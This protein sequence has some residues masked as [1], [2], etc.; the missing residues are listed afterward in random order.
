MFSFNRLAS[1][2]YAKEELEGRSH[3]WQSRGYSKK[4]YIF[5]FT[6]D[7]A[8]YDSVV[9]KKQK[10]KLTKA[11]SLL[12]KLSSLLQIQEML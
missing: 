10:Q 4:Y 7:N 5:L 9:E 3:L 11:S 6:N 1:G 2:I 8:F 12:G